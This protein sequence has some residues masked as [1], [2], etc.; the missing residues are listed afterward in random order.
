[1]LFKSPL[2]VGET[3]TVCTSETVFFGTDTFPVDQASHP[4]GKQEIQESRVA[5]CQDGRT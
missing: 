5:M 2:L 3:R 1:M 4:Y